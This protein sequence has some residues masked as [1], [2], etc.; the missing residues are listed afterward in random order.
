MLQLW[1][2]WPTPWVVQ[3]CATEADVYSPTQMA[4]GWRVGGRFVMCSILEE[5]VGQVDCWEG[6]SVVL[7]E[8]DEENME[9]ISLAEKIGL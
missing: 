3:G 7:E 8:E 6:L 5:R 2:I 9:A 4:V 1:K